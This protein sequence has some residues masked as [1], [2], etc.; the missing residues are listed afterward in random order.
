MVEFL[1]VSQIFIIFAMYY[2]RICE[3]IFLLWLFGGGI[4]FSNALI[5]K[6]L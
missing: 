2:A 6:K 5:Y 3:R 4:L 1:A